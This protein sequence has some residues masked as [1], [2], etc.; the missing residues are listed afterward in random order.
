MPTPAQLAA[1]TDFELLPEVKLRRLRGVAAAALEGRLD[2]ETLRAM[3]VDEAEGRLRELDG[4]GPFYAQLVTVRTLGH[5]D[6]TPT[7]EPMVL[8]EAGRLLG[9]DR[10]LTAPELVEVAGRWSPW[11]T[12]ACVA[13]RAAGP[14]VGR[15][16]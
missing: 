14:L 4:I 9:Y 15:D 5:T 13:I 1:L 2:T 11:R 10:P 12:W 7:A 8:A 3:P 16:A 6:V